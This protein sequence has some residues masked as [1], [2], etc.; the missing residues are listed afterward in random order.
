M[1]VMGNGTLFLVSEAAISIFPSKAMPCN[2][3]VV[4][5]KAAMLA[6]FN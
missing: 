5:E 3:P 2:V 1:M 6:N 4:T